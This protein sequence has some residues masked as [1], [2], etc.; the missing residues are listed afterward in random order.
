MVGV[1]IMTARLG[2]AAWALFSELKNKHGC[3]G[4]LF[5]NPMIV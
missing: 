5:S 2:W 3:D 1:V 4:T